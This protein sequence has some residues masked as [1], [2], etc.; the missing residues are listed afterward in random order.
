M[1]EIT[2]LFVTQENTD[3]LLSWGDAVDALIAGHHLPRPETQDLFLGHH[4]ET[5]L[6]RAAW[7]P[8]LGFGT[9]AV[10]VYDANR[11][12]G[13]PTVQGAMIVFDA[14]NGTVEA[15]VESEL[16]TKW[17]TAADS[18]LGSK[19]LARPDSRTLLIVGSG[20]VALSLV[21]A[22]KTTFPNL[23]RIFIWNRTQ[24]RAEELIDNINIEGVDIQLASNLP[25]AVMRSDIV[26]TATMSRS[27]ILQGDWIK[28]GTHVDLIGAFKADMREADDTLMSKGCLFVDSRKTTIDH[29]GELMI[30]IES[31]VISNTDI[32]ADLYDL[33]GGHEGRT[34]NDQIT[35]YK[36]GGGAHLDLM[37]AKYAI[38]ANLREA[39]AA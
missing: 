24:S 17:K 21:H 5:L 18:V 37:I 38:S 28:P 11:S 31:G 32:R 25:K 1:P 8:G 3:H 20:S 14:T 19:F 34:D 7:I 22:Y 16:V 4:G 27:P 15:F 26:A 36:N 2:P 6:N 10:T 23:D 13:F 33:I 39:A 9:K 35:V 30:P 29:I 12:S